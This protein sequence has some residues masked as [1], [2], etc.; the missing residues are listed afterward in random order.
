MRILFMV[1]AIAAVF[2]FCTKR[3]TDKQTYTGTWELRQSN[4]MVGQ[5]DYE[6]G[7]GFKMVITKDSLYEY[8]NGS[9]QYSRAFGVEKDTLRGYGA[10]R[11]ADKLTP[12]IVPGFKTFFELNGNSLTRY[13][14]EPALDGGSSTYVKIK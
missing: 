6:P 3:K 10:D 7:N 12:D 11:I 9:L 2:P 13:V 1:V 4:G 14:G 5:V 8:A